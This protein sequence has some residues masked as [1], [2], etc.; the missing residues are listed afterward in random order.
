MKMGRTGMKC[1][2]IAAL[3]I[4]LASAAVGQQVPV[5]KKYPLQAHI[6]SVEIEQQ[7]HLTN[8]TGE[9]TTSHVMKA[10][11]GGKTY[12]LAEDLLLRQKRPFQHRTWLDAG[13]YPARRT[14]HGFEFEYRDA[15][16]VRHEELN[17]VSVE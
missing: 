1:V 11:I 6:V 5:S 10:E 4:L 16:T 17:I 13:F 12:R 7:Q 2:A 14:K 8:G 3:T 9:F 15:E